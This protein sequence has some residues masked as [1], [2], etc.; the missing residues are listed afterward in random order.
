[1]QGQDAS[2]D[3]LDTKTHAHSTALLSQETQTVRTFPLFNS[4]GKGQTLAKQQ[5]VS[6]QLTPF[7]EF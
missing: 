2:S 4:F 6:L 1:M 7:P 5:T 3:G